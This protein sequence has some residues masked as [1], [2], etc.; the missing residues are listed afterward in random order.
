MQKLTTSGNPK[1]IGFHGHTKPIYC[2]EL[3]KILKC[4]ISKQKTLENMDQTYPVNKSL[5]VGTSFWPF[6]AEHL[7][8]KG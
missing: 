6:K 4:N 7:P 5:A 8:I 3:Y 2:G 1:P